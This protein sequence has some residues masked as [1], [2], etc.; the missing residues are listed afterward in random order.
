MSW[1]SVRIWEHDIKKTLRGFCPEGAE[2]LS[3]T[4]DTGLLIGL[5]AWRVAALQ[6][7]PAGEAI[8]KTPQ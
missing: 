8:F 6:K 1:R 5:R 7:P 4:V 2:R 3:M